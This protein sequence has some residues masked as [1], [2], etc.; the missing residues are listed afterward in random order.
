F[1]VA[2]PAWTRAKYEYVKEIG[3]LE[4][5]VF[6]PEKWKANYYI[7]AFD[8]MLPD[9][10]FWAAR[11]VMRF[12]EPEIRAMVGT[13]QFSSQEGA[14]YLTRTLVARQQK[15]GRTYFSQVLPL[16]EFRIEGGALRFEDL[17]ARYGFVTPRKFTFS[18]AVFDNQTES[19]SPIAGVDSASIPSST[20]PYL[21]V[22]INAGDAARK[23]SVYLRRNSNGY[24]V[25]GIERTFPPKD[26][27]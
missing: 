10:A 3:R 12:T 24:D 22:D 17:A 27:T 18:W 26:K 20:A 15:I 4:A 8:N 16:D 6:D 5:N 7:P 2:T 13:A 9:D 21:T 19:R 25:V 11:T 1:G 23:V 14:D